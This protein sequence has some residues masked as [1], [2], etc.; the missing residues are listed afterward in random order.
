MF[1]AFTATDLPT[2]DLDLYN[3]SSCKEDLVKLRAT[4][5]WLKSMLKGVEYQIALRMY[6]DADDREKLNK[7]QI[8]LLVKAGIL[9][10]QPPVVPKSTVVVEVKPS[11]AAGEQLTFSQEDEVKVDPPPAPVPQPV[12]PKEEIVVPQVINDTVAVEKPQAAPVKVETVAVKEEREEPQQPAAVA[13]Q[14]L[15]VAQQSLATATHLVH[16]LLLPSEEE[17][18][19]APLSEQAEILNDFDQCLHAFDQLNGQVKKAHRRLIVAYG[20][21]VWKSRI[22]VCAEFPSLRT[23]SKYFSK[24]GKQFS[25]R[26]GENRITGPALIARLYDEYPQAFLKGQY[27]LLESLNE[28]NGRRQFNAAR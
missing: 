26:Y 2:F 8:A 10:P 18:A 19:K 20:E 28:K 7:G 14:T 15:A 5:K 21:S 9:P 25:R 22:G 17:F 12:A 16:T 6:Y 24:Y 4:Q 13:A 1:T 3:S 23:C 11:P 27:A